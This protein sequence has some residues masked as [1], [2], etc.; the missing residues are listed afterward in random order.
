M[1]SPHLTLL[2]QVV[3]ERGDITPLLH[4]GLE[5]VQVAELLSEAKSVGL[6]QR[7]ES[8]LEVTESGMR[9]LGASISKGHLGQRGGWIRTMD[10]HRIARLSPEE[11]FLPDV[12]P[13]THT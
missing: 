6:V 8:G 3:R 7:T 11:P 4:R 1:T 9:L 12:P 13:P 5:L 2:L 10:E